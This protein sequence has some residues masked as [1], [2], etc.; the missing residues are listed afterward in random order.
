MGRAPNPPTYN[1]RLATGPAPPRRGAAPR[2]KRTRRAASAPAPVDPVK[3]IP[4]P[5]AP[6]PDLGFDRLVVGRNAQAV[7][8]LQGLLNGAAAAAPVY[9]WGGPGSGKT[10]LLQALAAQ[11]QADGARVGWFDAHTPLPWVLDEAWRLVV[12]DGCDAL[13]AAHQQ[14]AFALY[15]EADMQGVQW[16]AGGRLP[17]VDLALRDDLRSRLG[18]GH[19]FALHALGEDETR[20]ALRR[21]A[22]HRG[23]F[24]SDEVMDY[25]LRHLRRDL[26][27]LMGLLARLDG[28]ALA[29]HRPVTVPLLKK[30]LA[31][32]AA[33]GQAG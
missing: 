16:A 21:E 27:H 4:L 11:Q 26:G 1:P 22:D 5:I 13:D 32:S 3:Q 2:P 8:H 6:P 10:R 20:A 24:L 29:E 12:V 7:A 23:I 25:V 19:V 15:V 31:E 28:Y 14:A 33:Q 18:W 9:L 17:P 30:L